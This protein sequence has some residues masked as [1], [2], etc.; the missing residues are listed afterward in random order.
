[1]AKQFLKGNE[2]VIKGAVLSFLQIKPVEFR[3]PTKS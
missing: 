2:A 3:L 1:M